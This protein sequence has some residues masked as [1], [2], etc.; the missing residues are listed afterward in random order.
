MFTP[1]DVQFLCTK[2]EQ[3]ASKYSW[4]AIVHVTLRL[5]KYSMFPVDVKPAVW[6][7]CNR[8]TATIEELTYLLRDVDIN[9]PG[10]AITEAA[11]AGSAAAAA[12]PPSGAG[13]GMQHSDSSA[14]SS[15]SSSS[16]GI[17]MQHSSSASSNSSSSSGGMDYSQ[18]SEAATAASSSNKRA[19]TD[20]QCHDWHYCVHFDICDACGQKQCR[21]CVRSV[22]YSSCKK[23]LQTTCDG[24]ECDC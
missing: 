1:M 9:M 4:E 10:D 15:S 11:A 3:A 24:C 6:P 20:G 13:M 12:A 21:D 17:D 23:C 14:S 19:K 22:F 7:I 8:D 5:A 2:L 16:G 18:Q